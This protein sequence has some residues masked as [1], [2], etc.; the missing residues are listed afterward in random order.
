[1]PFGPVAQ[2]GERLHGMEEV[3]GS[4]PVGST[5]INQKPRSLAGLFL[6][7]SE[8]SNGVLGGPVG[9]KFGVAKRREGFLEF[10]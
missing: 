2:L 4:I 5:T 8:Q 7:K 3:A 10:A 6:C 1:M 9:G